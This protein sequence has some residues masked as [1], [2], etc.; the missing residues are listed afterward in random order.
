M[1]NREEGEEEKETREREAK[2]RGRKGN[3]GE[4]GEEKRGQGEKG[5]L[6]IVRKGEMEGEENVRR[7]SHTKYKKDRRDLSSVFIV[8]T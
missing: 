5:F 3:S 8:S 6:R 4:G 7:C 1:R 2:R